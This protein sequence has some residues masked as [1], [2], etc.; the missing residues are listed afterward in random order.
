LAIGVSAGGLIQLYRIGDSGAKAV[1]G[2]TA[3]LPEQSGH[4]DG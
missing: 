1:W 2:S 4:G 3:D